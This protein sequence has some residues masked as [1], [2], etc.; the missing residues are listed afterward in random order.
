MQSWGR[1]LISVLLVACGSGHTNLPPELD[2]FQLTTIEDQPVTA[3]IAAMDPEDDALTLEIRDQ[4]SNGTAEVD[5]LS[6]TYTPG[7]NYNGTD[8]FTL[9]ASDGMTEVVVTV[10]VT[11]SAEN[12][13]PDGGADVLAA[14]ED[15]PRTVE[16]VVL[17]QNDSD[18]ESDP[19]SII[20]A[21]NA[22]HGTVAV[23]A[24]DITFT[25]DP[26][27][28]GN[29]SFTYS[30]S[31]GTVTSQVEVTVMVGGVNDAPVAVDDA[32]T[33]DEDTTAT[34]T[35]LVQ[36]DT[37][38]EGQALSIASVASPIN[39]SVTLVDAMTVAFTPD[40]NFNGTASFEYTVTDGVDSDTGLVTVTVNPVNDAP[41]AVDDIASARINTARD[42][43]FAT[44]LAN[45]ND[46]G[47]G[48]ALTIT[49]V[50]N[51]QNGTA[52]LNATSVTF[53]PDTDFEGTASFEYV[54]SDG[55]DTDAGLVTVNVT[56]VQTA[57]CADILTNIPVWGLAA[58]GIDLRAYTGSTLHWIGCPGNG[59]AASSF[60]CTDDATSL[61]FGTTTT[62]ALRALVDPGDTLGDTIP[63]SFTTCC[64]ASKPNDICNAPDSASNAAG[65]DPV[66]AMCRA[67]GYSTGTI[68]REVTSNFCPKPHA[69]AADG[70]SWTSNFVERDGFGA[71][72]R[73]DL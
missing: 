2:D 16:H 5:G 47:D 22:T 40:A 52:T 73:C 65:F 72:F 25:P 17:L 49:A 24:A 63:A 61:R 44:L 31:D 69:L 32:V 23:T 35:T 4:P 43:A 60:Y 55:I 34:L 70:S 6:I 28:E 45:D 59:C 14:T 27:F 13:A 19:L 57:K 29:G 54:V 42:I 39:G 46:G 58:T 9:A 50:Q 68:V 33:V 38:I 8:A 21:G 36:N 67:L 37:D 26:N 48:G 15:M 18:V 41:V 56:A 66:T 11:V 10:D 62:D 3:T 51:Q 64:T 71:E 1:C 30:L 12:D 53:T 7:A 20:D